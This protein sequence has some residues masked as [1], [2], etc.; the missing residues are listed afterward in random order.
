MFLIVTLY[1]LL[2]IGPLKEKS[3]LFVLFVSPGIFILFFILTAYFTAFV[4]RILIGRYKPS[5]KPLWSMF[6]W[7]NE[8]VNA[9]CESM[10]YPSLVALTMGTPFASWFF[11]LMG[12]K[13]GKNVYFET[14]EI[15]E[16]DLVSI[17][18]N[19]CLNHRCTIQTHLFEDRVMKMSHLK[20]GDNCNVGS[21]SVVLYDSVMENNCAISALSLVMKGEV[22]QQ[23]T[24]WAGSPAKFIG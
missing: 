1:I 9:L 21:M 20:I 14:T 5:N 8:L 13:V 7:K 22:I 11:R 24:K 2:L 18:D 19:V 12:V 23:G 16:F 4:K 17:G 10:V 15:T 3:L 6:V